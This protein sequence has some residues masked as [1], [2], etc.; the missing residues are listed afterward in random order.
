MMYYAINGI[1]F[2]KYIGIMLHHYNRVFVRESSSDVTVYYF[3]EALAGIRRMQRSYLSL[4]L[5]DFYGVRVWVWVWMKVHII[6]LLT[7]T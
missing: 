5:L 6:R 3:D 2:L 4:C 1:E 7:S